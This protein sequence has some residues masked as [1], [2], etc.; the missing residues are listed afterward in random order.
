MTFDMAGNTVRSLLLNFCA[1]SISLLVFRDRSGFPLY[2]LC[3]LAKIVL[4]LSSMLYILIYII[5]III[6]T[7]EYYYY[8]NS[9]SLVLL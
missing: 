1:E 7:L 6:T 3:I 2:V 4:L 9:I 8:S 5:I